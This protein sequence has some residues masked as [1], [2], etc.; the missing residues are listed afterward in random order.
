ML[1]HSLYYVRRH[2]VASACVVLAASS[3]RRHSHD[4]GLRRVPLFRWSLL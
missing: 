2:P 4:R 1:A 3:Y